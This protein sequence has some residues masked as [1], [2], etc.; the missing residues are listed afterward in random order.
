M[1]ARRACREVLDSDLP[2]E[3]LEEGHGVRHTAFE[4]RLEIF[5]RVGGG[6]SGAVQMRLVH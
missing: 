3:L 1:S 2:A 6:K 5:K 4:V